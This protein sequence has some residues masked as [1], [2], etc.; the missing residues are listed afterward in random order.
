MRPI[1]PTLLTKGLMTGGQSHGVELNN[2]RRRW[3]RTRFGLALLLG[4][5]AFMWPTLV[6]GGAFFLSDTTAYMRG[7]D[8]IANYITGHRSE[9][10]DE[11]LQVESR[12]S[13]SKGS[14]SGPSASPDRVIL[15]GR[16]VYY[17]G[18]L[19]LFVSLGGFI[20]M[21]MFQAAVSVACAALSLMRLMRA[22]DH[23]ASPTFL[24]FALTMVGLFTSAGWF[25]GYMLPDI[26]AGLGGLAVA[27]L[28]A[29]RP[30]L[31]IWE[32][33]FWWMILTVSLTF[34]SANLLIF[35]FVSCFFGVVFGVGRQ[36]RIF[37]VRLLAGA[38]A[39]GILSEVIFGMATRVATG[40]APVRP[41]FVAARLIDDGPGRE[42]LQENCRRST[43]LL[44]EWRDRL[45]RHSDEI[46]WGQAPSTSFA[47][48]TP[49]EKRRL[50][51]EELR[52]IKAVII[53]RPFSVLESS[54]KAILAELGKWSLPEFN[55]P[56]D[57]TKTFIE[58]VP[59]Q[60]LDD[61]RATL[62][63]T[64]A[65]PTR[66]AVLSIRFFF[67][68]SAVSLALLLRSA[69]APSVRIFVYVVGMLFMTNAAISGMLST[70]H[71][72][73]LMRLT[74]IVPLA[75]LGLSRPMWSKLQSSW[76]AGVRFV[77]GVLSR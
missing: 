75:A 14:A 6:N 42:Y 66:P 51:G 54:V 10:S 21:A 26:F 58:K 50:A 41:P 67:A 74:W 7:P 27:N 24:G 71:D 62:A 30:S 69:V 29:F 56:P 57:A 20:S 61:L 43:L 33:L 1:P 11:L 48:G 39:I 72:R 55:Y 44:C 64:S 3:L 34:H 45:P 19:Y 68:V 35:G 12:P 47:S 9:W 73:Y 52:F 8:A 76:P 23:S 18:L 5:L 2:S 60:A 28:I 13:A 77:K 36:R 46:L 4:W 16:S 31:S 17:G 63:W 65:M 32:R 70:P 38:L 15:A 49:A 59:P 37:P 40:N 22:T 53:D 25:S